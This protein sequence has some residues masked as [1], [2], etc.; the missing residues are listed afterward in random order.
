MKTNNS[1]QQISLLQAGI[2]KHSWKYV[3]H[4][5]RGQYR[6]AQ[7]LFR[8]FY[9][10]FICLFSATDSMT[11]LLKRDTLLREHS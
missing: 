3:Y 10:S 9:N 4:C 1:A 8:V 2:Q 11:G 5:S 6:C 7:L